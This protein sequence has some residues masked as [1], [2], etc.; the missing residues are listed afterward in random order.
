MSNFLIRD[1]RIQLDKAIYLMRCRITDLKE[2]NLLLQEENTR[3]KNRPDI[4]IMEPPPSSTTVTRKKSRIDMDK[5]VEEW[6][7]GH[8]IKHFQELFQDKYGVYMNIKP[9]DWQAWSFRIKTFRN[10]HP[11]IKDNEVFKEMIEW[12]FKH[13]FNKKFKASIYLCTSDQLFYNWLASH[14]HYTQQK[15]SVT[16]QVVTEED[17]KSLDKALEDAF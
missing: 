2:D 11:E 16:E 6:R 5:P 3:L 17:K 1:C 9:K 10:T 14:P 4:P 12:L 13:T 7:S 8:F 15:E